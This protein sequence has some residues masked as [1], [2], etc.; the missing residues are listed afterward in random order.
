MEGGKLI[1]IKGTVFNRKLKTPKE[2][3][4]TFGV[5]NAEK[6]AKNT[7]SIVKKLMIPLFSFFKQKMLKI[8]L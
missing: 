7:S 5:T 3:R 2:L 1:N 8:K 6:I 4:D